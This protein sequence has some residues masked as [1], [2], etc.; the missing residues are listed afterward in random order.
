MSLTK[1][2]SFVAILIS[3]VLYWTTAN[4][5]RYNFAINKKTNIL[6]VLSEEI[7][8]SIGKAKVYYYKELNCSS[9]D[10]SF[11]YNRVIKNLE[12]VSVIVYQQLTTDIR[13]RSLE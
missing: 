2:M 11:D 1:L 3:V 13:G 5:C 4:V 9:V 7:D 10:W 6:N 12:V 8:P